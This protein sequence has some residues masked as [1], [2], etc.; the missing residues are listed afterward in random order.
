MRTYST[1]DP[2]IPAVRAN[3]LNE[4]ARLVQDKIQ[5]RHHDTIRVDRTTGEQIIYHRALS[6]S[7]AEVVW[8]EQGKPFG[9]YTHT[10]E[11]RQEPVLTV[12]R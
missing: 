11:I 10:I 2:Q 7:T 5:D 9:A 6:D 4:A 3:T 1:S 8:L 12:L